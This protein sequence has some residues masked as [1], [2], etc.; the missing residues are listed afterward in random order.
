[1]QYHQICVEEHISICSTPQCNSFVVKL[2]YTEGNALPHINAPLLG[3]KTFPPVTSPQVVF[4][5]YNDIRCCH[6]GSRPC[7]LAM[8]LNDS[9]VNVISNLLLMQLAGQY[10]LLVLYNVQA[11]IKCSLGL[12][13][14]LSTLS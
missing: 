11:Y 6:L 12:L 13:A 8:C 3:Y 9:I 7:V 1:M 4:S 14:G 10:L 5:T 2:S